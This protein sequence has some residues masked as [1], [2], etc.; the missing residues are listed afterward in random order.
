MGDNKTQTIAEQYH[1]G[2]NQLVEALVN[3]MVEV[4]RYSGSSVVVSKAG[5]DQIIV[6]KA[7]INKALESRGVHVTN[8]VFIQG[9]KSNLSAL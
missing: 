3:S 4:I 8:D 1:A 2:L 5:N 6:P 7:L 9:T